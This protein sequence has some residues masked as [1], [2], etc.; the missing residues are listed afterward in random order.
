MRLVLLRLPQGL[1]CS[2][3]FA[4]F[5]FGILE[6]CKQSICSCEGVRSFHRLDD[7]EDCDQ[8]RYL[9]AACAHFGG[10][11]ARS[12]DLFRTCAFVRETNLSPVR[13][14]RLARVR[15][16]GQHSSTVRCQ[17]GCSKF[18]SL[19]VISGR[20]PATSFAGRQ[21]MYSLWLKVW[22]CL[23]C[24]TWLRAAKVQHDVGNMSGNEGQK[25]CCILHHGSGESSFV[26]Q[27]TTLS[28]TW[29]REE[30]IK[31]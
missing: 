23:R 15:L 14:G 11:T 30:T 17:L 10:T 27:N 3:L 13:C 2:W 18:A 20:T 7:T 22:H 8:L 1:V 25:F 5:G 4:G 6:G 21:H 31:V 28:L 9:A 29:V 24:R 16:G 26:D 19:Y 12:T